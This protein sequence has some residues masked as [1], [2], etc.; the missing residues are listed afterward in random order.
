MITVEAVLGSRRCMRKGDGGN[1]G[2][3]RV[4]S[5]CS[6]S[7]GVGQRGRWHGDFL[8]LF[9][10]GVVARPRAKLRWRAVPVQRAP[11]S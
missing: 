7:E 11:R 1:S 2:L 8:T 9:P 3:D 6:G 10:G 4:T 5:T